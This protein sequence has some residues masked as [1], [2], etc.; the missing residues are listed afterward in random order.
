LAADTNKLYQYEFQMV[1]KPVKVL[2]QQQMQKI[3]LQQ[4]RENKR[5]A[6]HI[7]TE[8]ALARQ[9][10]NLGNVKAAR[11]LIYSLPV[12]EFDHAIDLNDNFYRRDFLAILVRYVLLS[13]EPNTYK[14]YVPD[15]KRITKKLEA[16]EQTIKM[17]KALKKNSK[18]GRSLAGTI[19]PNDTMK[20]ECS[21]AQRFQP[22][23]RPQTISL[24]NPGRPSSAV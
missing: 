24:V 23:T 2:T 21:I 13:I 7:E 19:K 12:E 5:L 22:G 14:N 15:L 1:N 18:N 3:K 8:F 16:L 20:N 17:E 11:S 6:R 9:S 4:E 10:L